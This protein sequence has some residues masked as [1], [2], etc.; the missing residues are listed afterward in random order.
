MPTTP[1]IEEIQKAIASHEQ[2]KIDLK[3]AIDTG[4]STFDPAI[5]DRD[6]R[7]FFGQWLYGASLPDEAKKQEIYKEVRQLHEDF[8]H[9][10]SRILSL[11]L[12]GDKEAAL[13]QLDGNYRAISEMMIATMHEWIEDLERA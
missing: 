11:G 7:C 3:S 5:V 12:K 2:W 6:D 1:L 8:H 10:A 13:R 4:K 9:V